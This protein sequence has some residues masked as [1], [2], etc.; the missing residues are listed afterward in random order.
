MMFKLMNWCKRL[1]GVKRESVGKLKPCVK[2]SNKCDAMLGGLQ[3]YL[4]GKY[5]F[6]YNLLS[7]TT[8]MREKE[9]ENIS[10]HAVNQ[11]TMNT[12]CMDA[13]EQGINCWDK[14]VSRLLN[15]QKIA[16]Y[17]PFLAYMENLPEWDGT[18]RVTGLAQRIS[19]KAVWIE[20]F[21]HWMLGVAAQWMGRAADCANSVAPLIVS[22]E[23]GKRKSTFCKMLMPETLRCYYIDKFSLTSAAA[24]EQ[25]L[26]LFGL[27]N[28]D[29][30]DQY[31]ETKT[32]ALKNLMQMSTLVFR[33]AHRAT[34]S[35][36]P[37]MAS[38]IGTSNHKDLLT[39]PTGSRRFLCVEV[40]GEGK[41]NCTP[42]EH[43][44]LFAQLKAELVAGAQYW[45][46]ADEERQIA[47]SNREFYKQQPEEEVFY[48][49]FRLP[50]G[51]EEFKLYSATS[52]FTHLQK[53]FP[54]AMRGVYPN[55]FAKSLVAIGAERVHTKE[56]NMYRVVTIEE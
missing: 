3:D 24:C 16:D 31:G 44:Q 1:V 28:L 37:R 36:L 45:F 6:R 38:F 26:S 21:H 14:D 40:E 15:S 47:T 49:C 42:L 43:K 50:K 39:D 5:D 12:L 35:N 53:R 2:A 9:E 8:E 7:E 41:I 19:H 10:Y 27:V 30:F 29:E 51:C 48:R 56:G 32:A 23:Q 55:K 25:K 34:F 52:I 4:C 33:K 20:G 46:T 54:A 17:H 11:R 18:D 22:R 13:R